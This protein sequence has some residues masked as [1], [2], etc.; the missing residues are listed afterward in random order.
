MKITQ[1]C[2]RSQVDVS[3]KYLLCI[4]EAIHQ[5][6]RAELFQNRRDIASKNGVNRKE[7]NFKQSAY[8]LS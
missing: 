3:D 8:N 6:R 1:R 5:A 7:V 2:G 4:S